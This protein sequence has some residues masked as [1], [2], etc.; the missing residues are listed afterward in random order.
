MNGNVSTVRV[1]VVDSLPHEPLSTFIRA[2]KYSE[3]GGCIY[4]NNNIIVPL[5][6]DHY[7]IRITNELKDK[8]VLYPFEFSVSD[9]NKIQ[10]TILN[11]EVELNILEEGTYTF[12]FKARNGETISSTYTF[13]LNGWSQTND[14]KWKY[15]ENGEPIYNGTKGWKKIN[16]VWYYFINSE[17]QTGLIYDETGKYYYLKTNGAMHTGWQLI[18]GKW[19]YFNNDM[20]TGWIRDNNKWYYLDNDGAMVTGWKM[21]NGKWYY[22]N[23]DMKT[24]WIKDNN[25]WYYLSSN[26]EMLTGWQK[27]N[28]KWY[29]LNNDMKTGWQ[30]I[31]NKWYYLNQNGVMLSGWQKINGSWYYLNNDMKTGWIKLNNIWYYL[32]SNGKMVTGTH[33]INGQKYY[34]DQNGKWIK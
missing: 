23:N 33:I 21:I 13:I 4:E 18:N 9:P 20:K 5:K 25:K 8:S 6:Y 15:Y 7:Y 11:D 31:D 10:Y 26:G 22:L 30:L 14:G 24:G 34:F 3:S 12:Y 32:E 16:N 17:M 27:V 2:V 29:Y 1:Q 19:Y 28:D